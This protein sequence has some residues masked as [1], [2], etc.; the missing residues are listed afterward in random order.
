M[1]FK[2]GDM[3]IVNHSDHPYHGKPVVVTKTVE[4]GNWLCS[5]KCPFDDKEFIMMTCYLKKPISEDNI[6][7]RPAHYASHPVEPIDLI[8]AHGWGEAFCASNV[9]KYVSRYAEKNGDADLEKASQ[10]LQWLV[11]LRKTGR[12]EK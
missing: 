6:T 1:D 12:I 8:V 7:T 9:I 3:A 11:Q 10:Y 5:V 4:S 2:V